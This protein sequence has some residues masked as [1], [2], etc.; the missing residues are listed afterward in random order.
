[1]M[2]RQMHRSGQVLTFERDDTDPPDSGNCTMSEVQIALV[3]PWGLP[4]GA[5]DMKRNRET[6]ERMALAWNAT[7]NLTTVKLMIMSE[8]IEAK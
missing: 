7:R 5:E 6:A 8:A 4:D 3:Q 2:K 1:M